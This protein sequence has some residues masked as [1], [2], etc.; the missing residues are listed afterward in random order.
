MQRNC[1]AVELRVSKLLIPNTCQVPNVLLDEVM[2][3][4]SGGSLKVLLAIVRKTYG[5]QKRSDK[6]SFR[7]LRELTGLSRDAVNHAIKDLGP[8][9]TVTHGRKGVPTLE[10]VNEYALN[11]N[12]ETGELVRNSDQSENRT[13]Q[14]N[15]QEQV[16]KS[17]SSKP[18]SSKPNSARPK[19]ASTADPDPRVKTLL[20]GFVDKYLA[21]VGTPYVVVTGKDP[22][23]LKGL[24]IRGY[25]VP[26][27][28]AAMDSY[29]ANDFYSKIGFDIGGFRQSYNRL[30]SAGKKKQHDY[31]KDGFPEL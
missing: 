31:D 21:R 26:A 17:D 11:L 24:L 10:G 8:F 16:R 23:L 22:N 9:L 18:N 20:S 1:E 19:R 27:I 7:T 29:F 30:N 28:E 4:L 15:R 13:S 3:R 2:P 14:K 12:V 5:F 25:D 6:I